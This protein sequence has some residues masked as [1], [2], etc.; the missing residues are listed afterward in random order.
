VSDEANIPARN[1][2][3]DNGIRM[4]MLP[5]DHLLWDELMQGSRDAFEKIYQLHYS[6][7]YS[8]GRKFSADTFLVRDSIQDVFVEL[9]NYREK[10]SKIS[11]I[12][13]YLYRCLRNKILSSLKKNKKW[14]LSCEVTDDYDF[15]IVFSAEHSLIMEQG[16]AEQ[17]ERI[18]KG[19]RLL[20]KRQK[21]IIYLKFY[22]RLSYE[23][24]AAVMDLNVESA[25][26]L[27]SNTLRALR[28]HLKDL[29]YSSLL[30]LLFSM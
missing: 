19:L 20:T 7:L 10:L 18:E 26:K 27:L 23:E 12:K 11:S 17:K 30:A 21:E 2:P 1:Q 29:P 6:G 5:D 24:I 8:Y 16:L 4:V 22:S 13:F 25:Y 28:T 15:E 9:W 14:A 3:T